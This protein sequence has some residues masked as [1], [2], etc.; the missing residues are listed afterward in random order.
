MSVL[1]FDVV[2]E[3]DRGINLRNRQKHYILVPYVR[4]LSC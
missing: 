3:Y 4:E 2:Y 1:V